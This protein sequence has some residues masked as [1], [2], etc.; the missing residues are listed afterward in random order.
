MSGT[1]SPPEADVEERAGEAEFTGRGLERV[2]DHRILTGRAEYVHDVAPEN[3]LHMALVRSMHAHADIVD[4]DVSAAL[5]VP[6]CEAVLTAEDIKERYNPMPCGLNG[7]EEWSLADGKV[8][9][10]GEPVAAV[11]ATDRYVAEDAVDAVVVDY[12]TRDCV[13]DPRG[14][15]EDDVVVHEEFGSNVADREELVFGDVE[16]AFEDADR[17][18][19]SSY[20]WGRIS[21]VPL[22]TAGVVAQYDDD[23]DSFD[24]DCNIQLHTLVDDTVYE[25]LGY[26][27]DDVHLNV[28]ADVGGS[29]GTKIAIHRYCCLAAMASQQ[30]ERPVK[31]VEDR[32]ENLQ[33]GDMHSSEREYEVKLAV[34]DDGTI[35][36]LDVWF[37]DDFGAWP[38]YPVNQV[39]KPLSV[40]SNAYDIQDVRY[41]YELV[42]TNKTSQ[43]AYRGFGVPS[44]IYALEM[45][46]EEAARELGMDPDELRRRNLI[47]PDQMPYELPTKNIY[48]SGDFPEA[49]EEIQRIV[50]E[51]ER[52]EGGLL[53]PEVVAA[54]REE[55]K[56]RGVRPTVHIEPGVSGSDWTDRQRSDRAE[57]DDRDRDDVAELPEHLRAE[58]LADGTVKAYIATDTSGQGHQTL[59]S[60]LLADELG[61]LPSDIEVGY[62]D[63]VEAPTEYG[64]AAS[65][66]AVMLSGATA[67]LGRTLVE[68]LEALA[69][70]EWDC[71]VAEVAYRDGR[72][73][74][75]DTGESLSL[76]D[77]A[78]RDAD[79]EFVRAS[80]DYE[81]P[82]SQLEEFDEALSRKFPV[83]PTAAFAANAPIVEVDAKTGEVDIL[84]FYSLRD[85][86]TQLNPTI[87]EGQAHGGIAQGVGAALQEEFGYDDAGQPQAITLFDYK[88]P[89]IENVPEIKLEHTE[90]PSPF[91]ETGAK[92]TGEGGMID[93]PAAIAASINAALEPLDV[94]VDQIP[95]TPNR[96]RERIRNSSVER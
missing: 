58:V 73:E 66:M 95:F 22:E 11:V 91:T 50:D 2:E 92:G 32:I 72:V 1:Q 6:G 45:I 43:T 34:D 64:T 8:R 52:C 79:G 17:V 30:L 87:V 14:A 75:V 5:E 18:V 59:V 25:T 81:H 82:A 89:S 23:A 19:E 4:I 90:T 28:P 65:R 80:Y 24:I 94:T 63:S 38:R 61:V 68:N 9:Y 74:R 33:G 31:F 60:Q 12:E 29:F 71:G 15:L 85:C 3:C 41:E 10:V 26:G 69:A 27:P 49:F 86:G 70:R 20:S 21:G 55:G 96:V 78:N 53:D 67:G 40:V 36:G 39:L 37:V 13:V 7:F 48:D 54:K 62:L 57:L 93:G 84:K 47:A 44:H 56:Y 35:R 77:L 88:L 46:V 42:L 83:Y 51:H 16:G 76:A